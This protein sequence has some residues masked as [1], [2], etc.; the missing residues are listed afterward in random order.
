MMPSIRFLFLSFLL[1]VPPMVTGA[2]DHCTNPGEYT[3][4]RRCYVTDVQKTQKPFNSVV[5]L[6]DDKGKVYCTGTVVALR[7]VFYSFNNQDSSLIILTAKHCT[8]RNEDGQPDQTLKVML[9]NNQQLDVTFVK[10]GNYNISDDTNEDGDWAVYQLPYMYSAEYMQKNID[11]AEAFFGGFRP[12]VNGSLIGYGLLKIMSDAEIEEFRQRYLDYLTRNNLSVPKTE[13]NIYFE[14]DYKETGMLIDGGIDTTHKQVLA[15]MKSD[16]KNN[17]NYLTSILS[18]NDKLKVSKCK[19]LS[20]DLDNMCQ[21]WGGNSGGGYFN[22]YNSIL[23]VHSKGKR[24][25]GGYLHAATSDCVT[26]D[27]TYY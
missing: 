7:S 15:F 10:A 11:P 2:A 16:Y 18:D 13:D 6:V 8:D 24:I 1:C 20:N 27:S 23:C 14:S 4:D 21:S 19:Y 25:V 3:A 9:Q 26:P 5:A 12:G 17:P 22:N